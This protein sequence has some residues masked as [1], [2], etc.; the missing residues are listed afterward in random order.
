M[1]RRL[2]RGG[3]S[4]YISVSFVPEDVCKRKRERIATTDMKRSKTPPAKNTKKKAAPTRTKR[5]PVPPP[6][7]TVAHLRGEKKKRYDALIQMRDQLMEQ[8][9]TI[10][11]SSLTSSRQPGEELADVGS[12]NFT[13]EMGLALMTEEGRK[14]ALIEEA[15]ERL[16]QGSYGK[17]I[18]CGGRIS[19]LRLDAIPYAKLCVDG[20]ATRE[21]SEDVVEVE[22]EEDDTAGLAVDELTE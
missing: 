16:E 11:L 10:S 22:E 4:R 13:R 18:D 7:L 3:I 20:K 21:K 14:M 19:S 9:R 2:D 15:L 5:A 17:C 6:E 1:R 8:I 12:D